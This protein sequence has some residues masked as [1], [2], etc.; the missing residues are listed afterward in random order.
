MRIQQNL[1]ISLLASY[2]VVSLHAIYRKPRKGSSSKWVEWQAAYQANLRPARW[3]PPFFRRIHEH[4]R[5]ITLMS[6]LTEKEVLKKIE[7][8]LKEAGYE[9]QKWRVQQEGGYQLEA[10]YLTPKW[11]WLDLLCLT[12]E[13]NRS[14]EWSIRLWSSSTGVFP[15]TLPLAPLL[16][17]FFFWLPFSD[18]GLNKAGVDRF[19]DHLS[20][21]TVQ[22]E[23]A[24][25][26]SRE[27]PA[28][29]E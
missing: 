28:D 23:R 10:W 7:K 14:K 17:I 9:T 16:N 19:F 11:G 3:Q 15:M 25:S 24:V 5:S 21:V 1:L 12:I 8:S 27:L 29:I 2:G 18:H 20:K 22:G 6:P 13:Q 4:R 26:L